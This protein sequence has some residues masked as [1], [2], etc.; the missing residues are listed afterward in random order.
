MEAGELTGEG[1]VFHH[2]SRPIP[3]N[4]LH[5][6]HFAV[7]REA[8]IIVIH[9]SR[10]YLGKSCLLLEHGQFQANHVAWCTLCLITAAAML[11]MISPAIDEVVAMCQFLA[12]ARRE[13]KPFWRTFW[14]GGTLDSY[15]TAAVEPSPAVS[16][17]HARPLV[18]RIIAAMDLNNVPW[19]L[20][21][22]AAFGIWLM[23]SPGV[24]GATGAAADNA[25]LVGALIVT[26][27]VIAF[28]EVARPARFL[29]VALGL[30]L[31]AAPWLL[32]GDTQVSRWNDVLVGVAV[33]LLSLRR[34]R[35]EERFGAWNRYLV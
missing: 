30:W 9:P 19:N 17:A 20:L 32:A 7:A 18:T 35:I 2:T 13:G 8:T 28:G 4:I 16:P 31:I 33:V 27:S 10:F 14:V 15:K 1:T 34:G 29:N 24:L 5:P 3:V 26:W 22:S 12:G 21:L 25:H 6:P 11:I 23:S